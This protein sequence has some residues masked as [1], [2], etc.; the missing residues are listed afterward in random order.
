MQTIGQRVKD[1]REEK[2]MTQKELTG[3]AG[4]LSASYIANLENGEIKRPGGAKLNMIAR[5]LETSLDEL[6]DGTDAKAAVDEEEQ[7]KARAWCL[8][9]HCPKAIV[10]VEPA[11]PK[12]RYGK[13]K[14]QGGEYI[15]AWTDEGLWH[16]VRRY[17]SF[18]AFDQSGEPVNY[19]PGCG[20][21]LM[22]RCPSCERLIENSA[23]MYCMGCGTDLHM[24]AGIQDDM[25]RD[26]SD[27]RH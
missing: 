2:G 18:P 27:Y 7:A 17:A 21:L 6:V 13:R 25:D 10:D 11:D 20:R 5:G 19:C 22:Q 9:E 24:E 15:Y 14:M 12:D 26:Q 23:Q 16:G 4:D 3:R 8:N 1:L